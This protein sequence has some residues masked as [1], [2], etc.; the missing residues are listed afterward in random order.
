MTD[1]AT[2]RWHPGWK[3]TTFVMVMLPLTVALGF[4]Q[5]DRAE[6]KRGL[7]RQ[8]L[9]RLG[10][11]PE[12]PPETLANAAFLRVRLEGEYEP[13]HHYLVDNRVRDGR[14]GYWVVSRFRASDGRGWLVNRG[15]VAAPPRRDLLP[16]VGTPSGSQR[17]LGVLWPD[18]GLTPLLA[19]DPWPDSWPRRVQR[20]DVARMAAE[21]PDVVPVEVRLEPGQPG[22]EAAAP[23]NVAFRPERHTGYAVQWFA[24]AGVLV[25]AYLIFAFRR[26]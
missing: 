20:L 1:T 17:L 5:L 19:P 12:T 23:V 7:E 24:L 8:Y 16:P 13:G 9:E 22:V 25:V 3:M 11:L 21:G 26:G 15:W 18:T 10:M 4:W 14:P 2:R 6:L